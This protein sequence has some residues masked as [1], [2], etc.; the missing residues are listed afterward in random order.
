MLNRILN[1]LL[2]ILFVTSASVLLATRYSKSEAN[3]SAEEKR[4]KVLR[5]KGQLKLKPTAK[6]ITTFNNGMQEEKRELE[7]KIPKHVPLKVKL[8]SE[9]EK[10]FKDLKNGNWQRDFELEVTNTSDKPIYRLEL[11]LIYPEILSES[12]F[13]IGVPLRYG[14]ADF[15]KFDTRPTATD[16]PI[17]PRETYIFRIPEQ[18][19]QAWRAHKVRRNWP[20]PRRVEIIFVQLSF[21]DGTGFSSTGATPFP[22]NGQSANAPCREG[23]KQPADRIYG[24]ARI[25]FPTLLKH[26]LL[27]A[28][29]AFLPVKFS[30]VETAYRE[31]ETTM[32]PDINCPGTDCSFAKATTYSCV[33]DTEANTFDIVGSSD[34]YGH[35]WK[36]Q[37]I[38]KL[39]T[40][41][42]VYCPEFFLVPC[43]TPSP[44]PNPTPTPTPAPTPT[45]CDPATRPNS[46][47]CFCENL[48]GIGT[49]W[50][51]FCLTGESA[52]YVQYPQNGGCD[53][54]KKVNN[55]SD[56]CVCIAQ[57]VTC[58]PGSTWNVYSCECVPDPTPTPTPSGGGGGL[59][60]YCT[61]YYWVW[62]VS[63]DGGLTWWETGLVEYAGC[64]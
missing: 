23:P 54:S 46:T 4:M 29:A 59:I 15:V 25:T 43:V 21:G 32:L 37:R 63:Y 47:N 18:D 2:V 53:P 61:N 62:Y 20:D 11:F 13:K 8:K 7:D 36:D 22:Y 6:E 17:Q 64:W 31:P 12:G 30:L 45:D 19:Q 28:P 52:D 44:T 5:R 3:F 24:N 35:C 56:C 50:Q 26:S 34:P 33:C 51:C 49:T 60:Y 55:G 42:G 38:D 14:R 48:P 39:C 58:D 9:K 27:P 1:L 16:V 10:A 57:G 40:D 41:L